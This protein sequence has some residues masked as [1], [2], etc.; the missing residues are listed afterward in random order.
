MFLKK[1]KKEL[2]NIPLFFFKTLVLLLDYIVPKNKKI[3]IFGSSDGLQFNGNAKA[4]FDYCYKNHRDEFKLFFTQRK[5][6]SHSAFVHHSSLSGIYLMLRAKT[7]VTTHDKSD[8]FYKFSPR[9]F[10]VQTWHGTPLKK[11]LLADLK[12]RKRKNR[13]NRL[14]KRMKKIDIILSSSESVA[15]SISRCF[16]VDDGKILNIGYPRNDMLVQNKN[17]KILSKLVKNINGKKV[18]LYAPTWRKNRDTE[19]FPFNDMSYKKLDEELEK[20]NA[21]ILIR[22]HISAGKSSFDPSQ[23]KNIIAFGND[24]YGNVNAILPEVDVLITDYSSI[25]FDF[26]LLDRPCVFIPYDLDE[27]VK[28]QGMLYDNYDDI[29][30]GY[31]VHSLTD[32]LSAINE[33]FTQNDKYSKQRKSMNIL[34]NAAQ[35]AN[36]SEKLIAEIKKRCC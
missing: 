24:V 27:Y 15:S 19:F 30:A 20:Q 31:H 25:Y 6:Q 33:I 2:K 5:K 18:I 12:Q 28:E 7:I 9:K 22:G 16:G 32:F 36:T 11:L 10:H 21:V 14:K 26:L 3:I 8:V 17:Q 13:I 23:Y 1:I 4:F 35:T 34:F 29:M